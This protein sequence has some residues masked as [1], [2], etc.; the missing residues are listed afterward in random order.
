MAEP[1]TEEQQQKRRQAV[2][3][4]MLTTPFLAGAG[5]I[6]IPFAEATLSSHTAHTSSSVREDIPRAQFR[7]DC[8]TYAVAR[9]ATE[10]LLCVGEDFPQTDLVFDG[11]IG[12]W[13]EIV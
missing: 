2:R 4:L 13:P 7:G 3:D 10:S 5:L 9:L 12:S 8:M 6:T 11:L 1:L